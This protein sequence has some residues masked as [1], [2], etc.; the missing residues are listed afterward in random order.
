[1]MLDLGGGRGYRYEPGWHLLDLQD[2]DINHDITKIPWPV[3]DDTYEA[4]FAS[5]VLEHVSKAEAYSALAECHRILRPG[6][7]IR[8][9][10]PD[11]DLFINAK[12]GGDAGPIAGYPWQDLNS[13]L[14]GGDAEPILAM[15]HRYMY[16]FETLAWML[17]VTGF[18]SIN[19]SAFRQSVLQCLGNR[20]VEGHS[21]FSLYVEAAK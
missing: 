6:G 4:I 7:V 12:L 19:R 5:H 15:R 10:V 8:I 20:D 17:S 1:M 14:G 13:L 21:S 11:M 16:N 2:A 18:K 3:E 9:A